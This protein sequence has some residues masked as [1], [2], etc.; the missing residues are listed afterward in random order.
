MCKRYFVFAIVLFL[1]SLASADLTVLSGNVKDIG[2][3]MDV[4][5]YFHIENQTP[6]VLEMVTE[7]RDPFR[8]YEA[9][10]TTTIT[11]NFNL[12]LNPSV[13]ATSPAGG[14]WKVELSH[15]VLSVGSTDVEM[16]VRGESVQVERLVGGTQVKVAELR[17]GVIPLQ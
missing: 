4:G 2:L 1:T 10:R 15:Q 5:Y 17:I 13:R 12:T 6:L 14:T 3:L 7:A 8:T 16:C 11:A 9:C